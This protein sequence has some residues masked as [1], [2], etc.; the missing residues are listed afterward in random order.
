[1]LLAFSQACSWPAL[2]PR[3]GASGRSFVALQAP[4]SQEEASGI[5]L[6]S[7]FGSKF[8]H[9]WRFFAIWFLRSLFDAYSG[10]FVYRI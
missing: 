1:M 9:V 10:C 4:G 3:F 2:G 7:H 8:A 5:D 6:G